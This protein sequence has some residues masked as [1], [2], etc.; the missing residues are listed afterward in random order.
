[1]VGRRKKTAA[2]AS[3]TLLTSGN[4]NK[5]IRTQVFMPLSILPPPPPPWSFQTDLLDWQETRT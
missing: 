4:V 3:K 2:G 1:M 5:R